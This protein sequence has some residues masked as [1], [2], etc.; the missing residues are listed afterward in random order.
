M[1][2]RFGP[3]TAACAALALAGLAAAWALPAQAG[4]L[5]L[6]LPATLASPD[7]MDDP[8]MAMAD[9]SDL[10]LA[11]Q[12]ASDGFDQ[13]FDA[14]TTA[15]ILRATGLATRVTGAVPKAR[16]PEVRDVFA[17]KPPQTLRPEPSLATL[18]NP[19][20]GSHEGVAVSVADHFIATDKQSTGIATDISI[21]HKAG[22]VDAAFNLAGRRDF[23]VPDPMAVSYDAHLTVGSTVQLGLAAHGALGT[24]SALALNNN[25]QT[26]GPQLR[27][28]L[29]DSN[30]S[31]SSDLGYDHEFNQINPAYRSQVHVKMALK[32][33]L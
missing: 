18:V 5:T 32:L 31:L 25:P 1:T 17:V 24:I 10:E 26:A 9:L 6:A 15:N 30:V 8:G 2:S 14:E 27:L 28:N 3:C 12:D 7:G 11:A 22:A 33:K 23:N 29:I 16:V 21:S 19:T 20:I 13:K 4:V